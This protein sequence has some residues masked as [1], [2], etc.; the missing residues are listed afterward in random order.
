VK[1]LRMPS[2]LLPA[3]LCLP[4]AAAGGAWA[5][6]GEWLPIH[7]AG[8]L[9]AHPAFKPLFLQA[10]VPGLVGLLRRTT[11]LL[12]AVS[13]AGVVVGMLVRREWALRWLQGAFV[14]AYAVAVQ[15][16]IL[17]FRATGALM[18]ANVELDGVQLN[19]ITLVYLRWR[20]LAPA[21]GATLLLALP[22]L[23]SGCR[24]VIARYRRTT[25]EPPSWG[26]RL[27]RNLWTHGRYPRF[28]K[29]LFS[30]AGLHLLVIFV[31]P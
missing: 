4:L 15:Y 16:G 7:Y 23:L 13:V 24:I 19:P 11:E 22:Y 21:A 20:W 25:D 31:L 3:L 6:W 27:L 18:A 9:A 10:G 26:D 1:T 28:R 2:S 14:L 5:I 17:V 12:A 8:I 30:S 29:S